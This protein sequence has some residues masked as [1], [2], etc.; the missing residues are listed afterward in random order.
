MNSA[1]QGRKLEIFPELLVYY[2]LLLDRQYEYSELR[3]LFCKQYL[4]CR[5]V[6]TAERGTVGQ[7]YKSVTLPR[8]DLENI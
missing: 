7:L 5:P 8:C 4:K 2:Y 3:I 1:L 6:Y